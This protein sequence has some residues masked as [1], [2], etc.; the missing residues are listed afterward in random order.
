M[1]YKFNIQK[2]KMSDDYIKK[3]YN[4]TD[5]DTGKRFTSAPLDAHSL[6]GGGYIYEWKG[7]K[8]LWRV[9]E[10]TMIEMEKRKEIYYTKSG[11]ARKKKFLDKSSGKSIQ[12]LWMDLPY[13]R[14]KERTGYP[15]QKPL[16]LLERIIQASS[17]KGELVL[18]PFCGCATTCIAAE[19]LGRKWVGIDISIKAYDLVQTRLEKEVANP[20]E[21]FDYQK[22]LNFSTDPP[23]RTDL[24]QT[25]LEQKY[26]YVISNKAYKNEYKVGIGSVL[27]AHCTSPAMKAGSANDIQKGLKLPEQRSK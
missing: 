1:Q 21:L 18:D 3:H 2:E 6:Q 11:L 26:V 4:H 19:K 5:G 23:K 12:N 20:E 13:V 10:K 9:P 17:K 7:I 8:K 27:D 14:A 22:A 15:T 16:A 25:D 24:R